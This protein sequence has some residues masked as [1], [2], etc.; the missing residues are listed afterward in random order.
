MER[1]SSAFIHLIKITYP[2]VP[3][4]L[5]KPLPPPP[6][7]VYSKSNRMSPAAHLSNRPHPPV[8]AFS[9]DP[10]IRTALALLREPLLWSAIGLVLGVYLFY[11]GF[12]L[13]QRRDLIMNTP[14]SA[15]RA[16]ALGRVEV[17]GTV[18]GPYTLMSPLAEQECF[19]YRATAWE[20]FN[21][22]LFSTPVGLL[23]LFFGLGIRWRKLTEESLCA[24]FFLDDGTGQ[25]LIDP[26]GA[27]LEL[28]PAFSEANDASL[29]N[30]SSLPDHV[31]HF[32]N[33][34]GVGNV[35]EFKLEEFCIRPNDKLFVLGTLRETPALKRQLHVEAEQCQP[36]LPGFVSPEAADLQRR[37]EVTGALELPG[38]DRHG[39]VIQTQQFD[40]WPRM[41]LAKAESHPFF[42]SR[43]SQR[44]VVESLSWKSFIYIWGGPILTLVSL[45]Y[46]V[47]RF[48]LL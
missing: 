2:T 6:T 27:E 1:L 48:G 45:A 19:Y 29:L 37:G 20:R 5:P 17:S 11:R 23:C 8:D 40:L 26:R 13:L 36:V 14:R 31:R 7:P 46:L 3:G 43:R 39:T 4:Q 15:I 33:R 12:V 25:V 32:L 47:I 38:Y 44:E 24:P 16:A 9:Q 30:S 42:L 34:R 18:V 21:P 22:G 28:E 10:F 41:I 35:S